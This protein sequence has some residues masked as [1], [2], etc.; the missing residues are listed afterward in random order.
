MQGVLYMEQNVQESPMVANEW[1]IRVGW[2][3]MLRNHE[4]MIQ[5]GFL[6]EEESL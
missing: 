6:Q 5:W 4:D 1:N 3:V 2:K